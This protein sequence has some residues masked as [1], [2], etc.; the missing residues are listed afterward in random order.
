MTTK[1]GMSCP[2]ACDPFGHHAF[3]PLYHQNQW[4]QSRACHYMFDEPS[5][6]FS[7]E[8]R[9]CRRAL[10]EKAWCRNHRPLRW[11]LEYLSVD[12]TLPAPH[13]G[14]P[15][16]ETISTRRQKCWGQTIPPQRPLRLLTNSSVCVP[17]IITSMGGLC[18]EGHELLHFAWTKMWK[19][20]IIWWTCS[21]RNT[22][23]GH[24]VASKDRIF[25]PTLMYFSTDVW[26]R[27]FID[28]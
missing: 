9:G 21:L 6:R 12:I 23:N 2:Q 28:R 19:R 7:L 26:S 20:D 17:F 24:H 27:I 5:I 14:A 11:I 25:G 16:S 13:Q 8:L 15:K 4:P 10:D 1:E 18:R 22:L 3:L